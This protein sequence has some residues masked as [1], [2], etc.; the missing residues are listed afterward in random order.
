MDDAT[1]KNMKDLIDIGQGLL[2]APLARVSKSTGM[3]EPA[4]AEPTT[5]EKELEHF[6]KILSKERKKRF[7]RQ[8][9]EE[10]LKN[11]NFFGYLYSL[12]FG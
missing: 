2:K 9:R 12:F 3:Y 4:G 8:K 10:L 7:E 1:E 6:A 5:N 11:K